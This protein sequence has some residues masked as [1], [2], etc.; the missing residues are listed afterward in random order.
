MRAIL[1]LFC[2]SF[3]CIPSPVLGLDK[4]KGSGTSKT[5][6]REGKEFKAIE[7]RGSGKLEITVGPTT[8]ITVTADDNILPLI[9]TK[10]E[11]SKLTIDTA[12]GNFE[13]KVDIVIKV[14]TPKIEM[15]QS[16]GAAKIQLNGVE[17]EA[18]ELNTDGAGSVRILGKTGTLNAKMNGATTLDTSE[19]V[20][21][22]VHL[23]FRGAVRATVH[24]QDT[25]TV[26]M[27]GAGSVEYLGEPRVKQKIRG[28]GSVKKQ[29]K[30][31]KKDKE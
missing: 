18:L 5:E 27:E 24:A 8:S 1:G 7:I 21:K 15:L 6:S 4:L 22:A 10:T 28:A 19:L 29:E 20:A 31:D 11:L 12:M 9:E 17:N 2:V 16:A 23:D 25:L 3:I 13:P 30:K 26:A 14:T